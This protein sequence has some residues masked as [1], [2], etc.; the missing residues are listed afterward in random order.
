M[1]STIILTNPVRS[2]LGRQLPCRKRWHLKQFDSGCSWVTTLWIFKFFPFNATGFCLES[3]A[4]QLCS[5]IISFSEML[6]FLSCKVV[7]HMLCHKSFSQCNSSFQ[8]FKS[9]LCS[10]IAKLLIPLK[11]WEGLF[12]CSVYCHINLERWGLGEG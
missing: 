4:Y 12:N 11:H 7:V 8:K 2:L 10:N 5:K 1:F 6:L 3:L 9:R